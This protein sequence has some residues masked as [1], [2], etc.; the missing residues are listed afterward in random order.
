MIFEK[1]HSII[2]NQT[3]YATIVLS[4]KIYFYQDKRVTRSVQLS[5]FL[6]KGSI[7][8]DYFEEWLNSSR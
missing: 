3:F 6:H 5:S 1:S 2:K 4:S 7:A 8:L